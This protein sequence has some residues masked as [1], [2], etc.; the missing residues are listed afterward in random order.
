MRWRAPV[1]ASVLEKR[2]DII[3]ES[4]ACFGSIKV[5]AAKSSVRAFL[6]LGCQALKGWLA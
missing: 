1:E 6:Q 3:L 5:S 4:S 2:Q